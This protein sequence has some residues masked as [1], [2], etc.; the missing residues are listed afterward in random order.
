MANSLALINRHLGLRAPVAG[1]LV[2]LLFLGCHRR[3]H[4]IDEQGIAAGV[5]D[6][7]HAELIFHLFEDD[8]G[9]AGKVIG[10]DKVGFGLYVVAGLHL[11]L[12]AGT[13]QNFFCNGRTQNKA[14]KQ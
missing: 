11:L 13:G 1:V 7:G 12:A 2:Q 10:H 14:L 8:I 4:V 6:A 5:F 9:I 3:N